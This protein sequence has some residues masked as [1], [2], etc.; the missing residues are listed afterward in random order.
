[1]ACVDDCQ[2]F[3]NRY[4]YGTRLSPD[5]AACVADCGR[6]EIQSVVTNVKEHYSGNQDLLA[7][8]QRTADEQAS[9]VSSDVAAIN[10]AQCPFPIGGKC[11]ESVTD[12]F[13]QYGKYA[14]YGVGAILLL[15]ALVLV[16]NLIPRRG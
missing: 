4:I 8:T 5:E 6:A 16:S 2:H 7:L 3:W 14:L 12:I 1:M 10:A 9:H 11:F 15:Y 13:D